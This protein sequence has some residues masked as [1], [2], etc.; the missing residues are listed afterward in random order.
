[1]SANS[2]ADTPGSLRAAGVQGR[3]V[4][5]LAAGRLRD[6]SHQAVRR[7]QCSYEN[8]ILALDGRLPSFYLKQVAQT[9]VSGLEGVER[10]Q[11]RIDVVR[12][13]GTSN[14][15]ADAPDQLAG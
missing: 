11:N 6:S 1:M 3:G 4:V 15:W 8:G 12:P 5:D 2:E 10:I 7:L 9:L 14:H 13:S